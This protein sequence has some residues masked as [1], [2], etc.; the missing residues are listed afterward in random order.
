LNQLFRS[1]AV[2]VAGFVMLGSLAIAATPATDI[3]QAQNQTP[4]N[5]PPGVIQAIS[6]SSC[7]PTVLDAAVK[8]AV[9]ANPTL[10][11]DIAVFAVTQCP[12][13]A[14]GVAAAAAAADPTDAAAIVV[15]VITALPPDQQDGAIA[16][17]VAAVEQAVPD[18]TQQVT[19]SIVQLASTTN[20]NGPDIPGR[21]GGWPLVP[22]QT[23]VQSSPR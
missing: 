21:P 23:D 7:D 13:D 22:P 10:G 8:A 4:A 15:A 12:A 20:Q 3:A 17:I 18:A 9:T 11:M 5:I 2:A 16:G 19:T 6:Q 1:S 14:A